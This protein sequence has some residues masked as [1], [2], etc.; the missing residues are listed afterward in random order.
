[1]DNLDV[2]LGALY[3]IFYNGIYIESS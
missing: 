1:M 2:E 3:L